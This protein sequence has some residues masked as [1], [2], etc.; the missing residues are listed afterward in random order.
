MEQNTAPNLVTKEDYGNTA[1]LWIVSGIEKRFD[2]SKHSS[3]DL[4]L[5]GLY[6]N[7]MIRSFG[8]L[9]NAEVGYLHFPLHT[10]VHNTSPSAD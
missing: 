5:L 10:R 7:R 9:N 3:R 8:E 2:S 1:S 6:I 4:F